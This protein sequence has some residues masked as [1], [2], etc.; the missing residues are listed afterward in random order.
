MKASDAMAL[1]MSPEMQEYVAQVYNDWLV[2]QD[3]CLRSLLGQWVSE[4]EPEI[5]YA[6]DGGINQIIGVGMRGDPD[7]RVIIRNPNYRPIYTALNRMKRGNYA[8]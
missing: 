2:E 1:P 4:F 5:H 6:N 8:D 3:R 7:C